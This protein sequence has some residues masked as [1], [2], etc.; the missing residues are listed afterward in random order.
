MCCS[1]P[2]K[3]YNVCTQHGGSFWFDI[4]SHISALRSIDIIERG[5]IL[6]LLFKKPR[7]FWSGDNHIRTWSIIYTPLLYICASQF[8]IPTHWYKNK[9]KILWKLIYL[10][11]SV[12]SP[13]SAGLSL[14]EW[15]RLLCWLSPPRPNDSRLCGGEF[16][17]TGLL[18]LMC[19][20]GSMMDWSLMRTD[21][22]LL[23]FFF[24]FSSY[25]CDLEGETT[26]LSAAGIHV[27]PERK[28][29][30]LITCHITHTHP[31]SY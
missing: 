8:Y 25:C 30:H 27:H 29:L 7:R 16:G 15:Q 5:G 6:R 31:L 2:Y 1:K 28:T 26:T 3:L 21:F 17:A 18:R 9:I 4:Y 11:F 10:F 22:S 24:F 13:L 19:C 20:V 23:L 14:A 12:W